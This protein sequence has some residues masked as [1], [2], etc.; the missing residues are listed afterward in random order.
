[1]L[2]HR[3][4]SAAN[5]A[6]VPSCFSSKKATQLQSIVGPTFLSS[7][8][9]L[10]TAYQ[11]IITASSL[12]DD[13][14]SGVAFKTSKWLHRQIQD[15]QSRLKLGTFLLLA[16]RR[17]DPEDCTI[18]DIFKR[19]GGLNS[20]D[21]GIFPSTQ[22]RDYAQEKLGDIRALDQI[23]DCAPNGWSFRPVTCDNTSECRLVVSGV[24]KRTHSCGSDHVIP[25][26]TASD[27]S[28]HLQCLSRQRRMSE[29]RK[30]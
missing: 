12:A 8:H 13:I 16:W 3:L 17:H 26:L 4:T 9:E 20:R 1:M 25:H 19:F 22:E 5:S 7:N 27:V 14:K 21:V 29:R 23:A 6:F 11:S 18:R 2:Q 24:F 10:V 15:S 30:C 28:K